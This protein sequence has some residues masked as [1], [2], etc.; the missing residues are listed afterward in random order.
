MRNKSNTSRREILTSIPAAG[1][2]AALG[3]IGLGE[4]RAASNDI[5]VSISAVRANGFRSKNTNR[6]T[7]CS[8]V[9]TSGYPR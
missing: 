9:P 5:T 6:P 8:S 3:G 1:A 2:A 7:G 4:A